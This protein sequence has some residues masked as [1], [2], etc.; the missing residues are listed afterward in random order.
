MGDYRTAKDILL[1]DK[2]VSTPD[3]GEYLDSDDIMKLASSIA[4]G[5]DGGTYFL[6]APFSTELGYHDAENVFVISAKT[7]DVIDA[8]TVDVQYDDIKDGNK[9]FVFLGNGKQYDSV[10]DFIYQIYNINKS[11]DKLP[12]RTL[13]INA[14]EVPHCKTMFVNKDYKTVYAK[15]GELLHSEGNVT[16]YTD[17]ECTKKYGTELKSNC[18]FIYFEYKYGESGNGFDIDVVYKDQRDE[19]AVVKLL[20]ANAHTDD[21]DMEVY[22]EIL[23]NMEISNDDKNKNNISVDNLAKVY[24]CTANNPSTGRETDKY[25]NQSATDSRDELKKL[26]NDNSADDIIFVLDGSSF[27]Q[28]KDAIPEEYKSDTIKLSENPFMHFNILLIK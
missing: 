7:S 21:G 15:F 17:E 24:I 26:L 23:G 25:Y 6:E 4:D 28:Q 20:V 14:P 5:E 9:P 18:A 11:N 16:L 8:D 27:K 3:M 10:K 22:Y 13:G 2:L 12:I 1:D 19:D